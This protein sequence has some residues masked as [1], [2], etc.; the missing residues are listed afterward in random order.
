MKT[1]NGEKIVVDIMAKKKTSIDFTFP[2]RPKVD[3]EFQHVKYSVKKFSF[4][5]LEFGKYYYYYL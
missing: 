4:K 1:D 2:K 5:Q 3:I